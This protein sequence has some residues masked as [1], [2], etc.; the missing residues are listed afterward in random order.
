MS[1]ELEAF[2]LSTVVEKCCSVPSEKVVVSTVLRPADMDVVTT[3]ELDAIEPPI[4]VEVGTRVLSEKVLVTPLLKSVD[5]I[6]E[7]PDKL[8]AVGLPPFNGVDFVSP[9][10]TVLEVGVLS[11]SVE[12]T[13]KPVAEL[14]VSVASALVG[15]ETCTPPV[16]ELEADALPGDPDPDSDPVDEVEVVCLFTVDVTESAIPSGNVLKVDWT[17]VRESVSETAPPRIDV[18]TSLVVVEG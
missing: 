18:S 8:E 14:E 2:A 1:N 10:D 7:T 12:E 11:C 17:D 6:A 4:V 15:V 5:V 9:V 13:E 16:D 3:D